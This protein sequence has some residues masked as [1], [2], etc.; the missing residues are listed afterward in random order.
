M[1]RKSTLFAAVAAALAAQAW[2]VPIDFHGYLRSGSGTASEGGREAC[3]SLSN[4]AAFGGDVGRAG[5]LGNECDNYGEFE[6]DAGL[7]DVDGINFKLYTMLA[8]STGQLTDWE[9]SSPAWRQNWVEASHIGT[10]A[11]ADASLWVG[12]RYYKR[13]DVHITDFFW[14]ADTGPGAGIE[15]IDAGIGKLSYAVM[16]GST[17][18]SQ[19]TT[20][21]DI[22]LEGIAANPGGSIDLTFNL[23]AKN[24]GT[25]SSGVKQNGTNG[26][27]FGIIHNQNDPFGWGGFN[28]LVFQYATKAANLDQSAQFNPDGNNRKAWR[29]VEHLVFE[30]KASDWNGAVFVGYGQ[31]KDDPGMNG[32]KDAKTFSIVARPEY[33]FTN[34]YSLAVEAGTT[35]YTPDGSASQQL[36]KLTVAPQLAV[37]KGFWARPV[38]RAYYTY[39]KWNDAAKAAGSVAFGN[40]SAAEYA[41]RTSGS[42]YGFQMEAWW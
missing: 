4:V 30:P 20:N 3:F 11:L 35:R 40:T 19:A 8:Y 7:G 15:N 33:H 39:A 24:N 14:S 12:K 27:A 17:S 2:A 38:L 10:G 5:R 6:L 34:A 16:R 13:H 28:A 23:V 37:G 31:V 9:Q 1:I 41:N 29:V 21:N 26:T 25:D 18:A 42:S 22:R 32:G 36:T